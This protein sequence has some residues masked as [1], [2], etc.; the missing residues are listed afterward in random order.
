LEEPPFVFQFS[1]ID[2]AK[3]SIDLR[4]AIKDTQSSA[5]AYPFAIA[6]EVPRSDFIVLEA[7]L[8]PGINLF[9]LGSLMLLVGLAISMI[10]RIKHKMIPA[11]NE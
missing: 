3:E 6:N 11:I 5:K 10:Y 2:P 8:F 1:G 9:W 4:I 7:I